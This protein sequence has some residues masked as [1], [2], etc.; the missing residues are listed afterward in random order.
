[1][2]GL[3]FRKKSQKS[4]YKMTLCSNRFSMMML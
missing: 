1:M 4:I 3:L 2:K